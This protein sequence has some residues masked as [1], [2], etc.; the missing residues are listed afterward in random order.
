MEDGIVDMTG[1][2]FNKLMSGTRHGLFNQEKYAGHMP[3]YTLPGDMESP[4]VIQ[5]YPGNHEGNPGFNRVT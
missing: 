3:P 1:D 4:V 2:N 5:D